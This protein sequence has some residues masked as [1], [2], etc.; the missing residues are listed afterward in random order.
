MTKEN[1]IDATQ[2]AHYIYSVALGIVIIISGISFIA[3][4]LGIYNSGEQPF[5]RESVAAAFKGIAIPVYT[6]AAMTVIGIIFDVVSKTEITRRKVDKPYAAM[7]NK[8]YSTRTLTGCDEAV[9]SQ[10]SKE[11][12]SRK[13]HSIIRT[14]VFCGASIVFLVYATNSKNFHQSEI[15][16]SMISAMWV[17]LPCLTVC[18]AYGLFT[19][20]HNERSLARELEL[21]KALPATHDKADTSSNSEVDNNTTK[22]LVLIARIAIL[23]IGVCLLVHGFMTGG[24]MD[25]LTKAI[26]IC[27]E[28]IGLG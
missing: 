1:K 21:V 8:A 12:N 16:D 24:T 20:I 11:Q 28:C 15:T 25:V 5:T 19:I 26:N 9:R 7:L 22:M 17:L 6:C 3:A 2:R 27:T 4:C 23:I 10:I 18:F 13:I 14:I